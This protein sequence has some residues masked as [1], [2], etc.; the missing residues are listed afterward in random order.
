M[1]VKPTPPTIGSPAQEKLKD[2][3]YL[4]NKKQLERHTPVKITEPRAPR[5][6]TREL[7]R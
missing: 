6:Q 4:E 7:E 1:P 3:R 5:E 2:A